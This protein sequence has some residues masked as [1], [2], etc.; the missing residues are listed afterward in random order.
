M[1]NIFVLLSLFMTLNLV[2]QDN[3]ILTINNNKYD[4][5]EFNYIYS[6]NN[7]NANYEDDSLTA[8]VQKYFID[9][10]LK[11]IEAKKLGYDTIP[12]LINELKQY[13][14][15]LSR[16]YLIDKEKNEKLVE[17]AYD[18]TKNEIRASHILIRVAEDADPYDTLVAFKKIMNLRDRVTQGE[19]FEDVAS[20][21]GGSQDPSAVKNKGDLGYFTALQMV[22]KFEEAAFNLE[23]GEVSQPV[24]TKF[25]YHLIKVVDKRASLGKIQAAHIMISHS[26]NGQKSNA[27]AKINEIYA[28]LA[29]GEKFEELAQKYSDDQSSKIKGGLLPE[30]G[31][32]TKQRMVPE[33]EKAAFDIK[34]DGE[35]SAPFKTSYGWH[36]VKR[37]STSPVPTYEQMKRELKLKVEKDI[38]SQ[39]TQQSF[40][41]SLK[42]DYNFNENN[43]LLKLVTSSLN[44]DVFNGNWRFKDSTVELS[45]T[46]IKFADK[47]YTIGDFINHLE[48]N[49]RREK[50][51]SIQT[52]AN[53]KY[54]TWINQMI[55]KYED[56]QLELKHPA[57]KNLMREYEEGILIFEI[58]Q[59]EIWNKASTDTVGLKNYYEAHKTEFVYPIRYVGSLYKCKDK[60][61]AKNVLKLMKSGKLSD[62][63]IKD[64]LNIN[65][66]LNAD[67]KKGT[68]NSNSTNEFKTKKEGK[69]RSFKSGKTKIY[70]SN[71]EVYVFK[72][73]SILEPSIRKYEEAKGL[74]TAG[75]Q[76]QL[77]EEWLIK[78]RTNADIKINEEVLFKAET[79]K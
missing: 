68:F 48:V 43:D 45:Q 35:Y 51:Q 69:Y 2:A 78:L 19:S 8:Y 31:A 38:R 77:Q 72:T 18:R 53:Y 50:P 11:I 28:L 36:I 57:F 29:A 23:I 41:E 73:D 21:K 39:S 67:I 56:S 34:N 79:F 15:Q 76:N 59:N 4:V 62:Q 30:F 20:G 49:Q 46:M 25:G 5:N 58:M 27:E 6:K 22:Y 52:Y 40:I 14:T 26:N 3:T 61:T 32:G 55:L 66:Q 42:K 24:R 16:P 37:I 33:F 1:K 17:Q 70:K 7:D 10:K 75:Y 54:Q 44:N 13:R 9:Y 64:S 12:R 74:A 71:G 63:E 65:S 47:S 60:K